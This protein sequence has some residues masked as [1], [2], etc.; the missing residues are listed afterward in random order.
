MEMNMLLA[1][2]LR[3]PGQ[4]W[5]VSRMMFGLKESWGRLGKGAIQ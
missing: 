2:E 3:N 4:I 1:T 5:L